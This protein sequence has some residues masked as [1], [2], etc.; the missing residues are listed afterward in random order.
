MRFLIKA[1]SFIGLFTSVLFMLQCE[2]IDILKKASGSGGP[3]LDVVLTG[4]NYTDEN[5]KSVTVEVKLSQ[6]PQADVTVVVSLNSIGVTEATISPVTLLFTSATWDTASI[7]TVAGI[8][9]GTY[10]GNKSYKAEFLSA[11]TG[12]SDFDGLSNSVSLNNYSN[13]HYI[14]VTATG[15][16]AN[17]GDVSAADSHCN[18]AANKP[19]GSSEFLA[20][21]ADGTSRIASVTASIGDGQVGWVLEPNAR[22][23]R[24]DGAFVGKTGT[25]SLFEFPLTSEVKNTAEGTAYPW[26]GLTSGWQTSDTDNNTGWTGLGSAI[27]GNTSLTGATML[28]ENGSNVYSSTSAFICVE[29]P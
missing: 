11:S 13:D 24:E 18:S 5:G 26:T 23:Y 17:F 29:K 6:E 9:D 2:R 20:L 22:Y 21:I 3:S 10:D 25:N 8:D 4:D 7:V 28:D 14:F 1:A 15:L 12:D 16:T 27:R 19:A